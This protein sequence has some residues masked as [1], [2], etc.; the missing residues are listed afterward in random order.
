MFSGP[1]CSTCSENFG[2]IVA[3]IKVEMLVTTSRISARNAVESRLRKSQLSANSRRTVRSESPRASSVEAKWN[4]GITV[5]STAEIAEQR[6]RGGTAARRRS[7]V[8]RKSGARIIMPTTWLASVPRLMNE[9]A[10]TR[11]RV[12]TM[13]GTT[14]PSAG[15]A[16]CV[17]MPIPSDTA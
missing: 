12:R 7:P 6:P 10:A 3:M 8:L 17:T 14:A 13:Y 16:N 9:F 15:T 11:L 1:I 2:S 5:I 4:C